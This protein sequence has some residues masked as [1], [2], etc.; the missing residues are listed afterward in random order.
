VSNRRIVLV[1]G[2]IMLV[3]AGLSLLFVL[4]FRGAPTGFRPAGSLVAIEH[5]EAGALAT[6]LAVSV[7][8]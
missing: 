5:G 4:R 7:S 6:A 8:R 2:L 1:L 3:V